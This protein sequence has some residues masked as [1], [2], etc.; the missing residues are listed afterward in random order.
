MKTSLTVV[1][2]V[3]AGAALLEHGQAAPAQAAEFTLTDQNARVHRFTFPRSKISVLVL[4]DHQGSSQIASWIEPLYPP[5]WHA[6][7]D[8]RSC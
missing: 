3:L 1:G 4:S 2:A 6:H 5:L 7:R 8:R